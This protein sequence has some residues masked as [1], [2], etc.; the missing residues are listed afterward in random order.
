MICPASLGL[1]E[2]YEQFESRA[3]SFSAELVFWCKEGEWKIKNFANLMLYVVLMISH[4]FL[5]V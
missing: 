5:S 1:S 3:T 4:Q 2:R